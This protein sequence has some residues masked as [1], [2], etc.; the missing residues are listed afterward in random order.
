MIL[1]GGNSAYICL[2]DIN[3]NLLLK[4][5]KLTSNRSLDGILH[6]LNSNYKSEKLNNEIEKYQSDDSDYEYE[7]GNTTGLDFSNRN[8]RK[9]KEIK[10]SKVCFSFT[11]RSFLVGTT[12]GIYF[13]SLDTSDSFGSLELEENV[14]VSSIILMIKSGN[15]VMAI[16]YSLY[17]NMTDILDKLILMIEIDNVNYITK[18]LSFSIVLKMLDYFSKKLEIDSNIQLCI[19]WVLWILKNHYNELKSIPK[20][21]KGFIY[22]LNKSISNNFKNLKTCVE[23][24]IYSL[25]YVLDNSS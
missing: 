20:D 14:T 15:Y 7:V 5:F 6:K 12:E 11:N 24:N 21:K 23:E 9:I 3:F 18:C 2:Y 19:T 8:I 16:T 13:Y 17:L 10:I 22:N 1:A 25:D 4:K